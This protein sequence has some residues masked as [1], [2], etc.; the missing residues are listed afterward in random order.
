MKHPILLVPEIPPN[1]V[2]VVVV[3]GSNVFICLFLV[4][5]LFFYLFARAATAIAFKHCS[6]SVVSFFHTKLSL[7]FCSVTQ[8]HVILLNVT[9]ELL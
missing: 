6:F 2:N 8:T 7:S 3:A 5:H 9:N 4:Y 1:T